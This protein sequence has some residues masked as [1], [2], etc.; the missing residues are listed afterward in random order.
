[1]IMPEESVFSRSYFVRLADVTNDREGFLICEVERSKLELRRFNV[2][3]YCGYPNEIE[4]VSDSIDGKICRELKRHS[5]QLMSA[6]NL[7]DNDEDPPPGS[8][9][10]GDIGV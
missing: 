8:R 7:W 2:W 6:E 1:M 4:D 10:E 3:S 9:D 5:M